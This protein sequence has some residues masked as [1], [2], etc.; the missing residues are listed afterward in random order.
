[1]PSKPTKKGKRKERIQT[2]PVSAPLHSILVCTTLLIGILRVAGLP[3]VDTRAALSEE[4]VEQRANEWD[5]PD[6]Q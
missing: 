2:G 3:K 5:E 6:Y 1:M 4:Q